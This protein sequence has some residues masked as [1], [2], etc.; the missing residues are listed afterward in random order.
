MAT[1][2]NYYQFAD[3]KLAKLKK[4]VPKLLNNSRLKLTAFD[5]LNVM[6][7]NRLI[8][9]QYAQIE[10]Q[11]VQLYFEIA[12]AKYKEAYDIAVA[13]GYTDG[14]Y[15]PLWLGAITDWLLEYDATTGYVFNNEFSRKRDRLAE[16]IIGLLLSKKSMNSP[17]IMVAYKRAS[18]YINDQIA[19]FGDTISFKAMKQAYKDAG[20]EQV[21]WLTEYDDNVC[22]TCLSYGGFVFD[23]DRVP[24]K[25]HWGCRC[26]LL[27]VRQRSR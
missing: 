4:S 16:Q 10:K 5:E 14:T 12:K 18:K 20:V 3:K 9:E 13:Y 1:N 27:P 23:I 19:E 25:P 21:I 7:V 11:T 26:W 2:S 24:P 17:E 22:D 8:R 6:L 15:N